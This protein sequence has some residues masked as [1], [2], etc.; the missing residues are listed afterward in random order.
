[1]IELDNNVTLEEIQRMEASIESNKQKL[2][3]KGNLLNNQTKELNENE[4]MKQH[5]H[6]ELTKAK[7][8]YEKM[9]DED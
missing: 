4:K 3:K 6:D 9:K 1:M 8:L 7:E 5:I 2:S